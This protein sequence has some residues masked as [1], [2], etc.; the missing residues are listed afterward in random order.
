M[1]VYTAYDDP[2]DPVGLIVDGA[3]PVPGQ[4]RLFTVP[5]GEPTEVEDLVGHQLLEHQ[6]YKGVVRVDVKKTK[7]GQEY[8][9]DTAHSQSLAQ[10]E[11]YD[12]KRFMDYVRYCRDDLINN[13]VRS[14]PPLPPGPSIQAIIDR[15]GYDPARFGI[16][17]SASQ[18]GAVSPHDGLAVSAAVANQQAQILAKENEQL[19]KNNDDLHQKHAELNKKVDQLLAAINGPDSE[20]ETMPLRPASA[21]EAQA[22]QDLTAT[23]P[24]PTPRRGKAGART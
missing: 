12:E 22:T 8:D 5:P 3:T 6:A 14:K 7:T 21:T 13:P 19:R 4:G 10:L 20:Q 24:P 9:I 16:V 15:R 23:A 18:G 11:R 1:V 17:Y 2:D